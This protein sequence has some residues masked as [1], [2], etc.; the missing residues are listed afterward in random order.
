LKT[1]PGKKC[2]LIGDGGNMLLIQWTYIELHD[3]STK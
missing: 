3:V 2:L 1:K